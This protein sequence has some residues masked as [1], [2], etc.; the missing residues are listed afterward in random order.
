MDQQTPTTSLF[1]LQ[2]DQEASTY[3]GEAA[4]WARFLSILGF[5][6]CGLL[7]LVGLFLGSV[8]STAFRGS[9]GS[10][11]VFG[12]TFFTMLYVVIALLYFFPCLYL[13]QFGSKM[14]TAQRNNDQ[15][16]LSE[17]FKNLKSCFKFFGILAIVVLGLYALALIAAVIGAAVG[18]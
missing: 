9:M 3:L 2:M 10:G 6:M 15:Q 7:I 1:D 5:I 14:R 13:F 17:S 18:R 12:G 11:S 8:V 4:R 16:L